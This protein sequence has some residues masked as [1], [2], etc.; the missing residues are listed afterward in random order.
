MG[1]LIENSQLQKEEVE[2]ELYGL[3]SKE[4]SNIYAK[5]KWLMKTFY[6]QK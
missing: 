4:L 6:K 1:F 2:E 5:K 3:K